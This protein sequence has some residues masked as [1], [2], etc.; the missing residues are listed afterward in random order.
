MNWDPEIPCDDS[1]PLVVNVQG[2]YVAE[3]LAAVA[4]AV[5]LIERAENLAAVVVAAV[6]LFAKTES[7]APAAA[8]VHLFPMMKLH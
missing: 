2:S 7:W 1:S 8:A 3:S 4:F 6:H 5:H